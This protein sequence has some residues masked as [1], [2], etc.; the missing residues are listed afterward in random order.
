MRVLYA[1]L[2]VATA[3]GGVEAQEDEVCTP[4]AEAVAVKLVADLNAVQVG[5][6]RGGG[7]RK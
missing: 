1:L 5:P 3:A 7:P 4:A 2:L 6:W